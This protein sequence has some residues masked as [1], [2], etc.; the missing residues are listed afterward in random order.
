MP[1]HY[2]SPS[3]YKRKEYRRRYQEKSLWT[4][5]RVSGPRKE[6]PARD[7]E[8]RLRTTRGAY[9]HKMACVRCT[10][11]ETIKLKSPRETIKVKSPRETIKDAVVNIQQAR[12]GAES[13]RC[14][15][16]YSTSKRRRRERK[17]IK[18]STDYKQ[19]RRTISRVYGL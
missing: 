7:H 19:S 3:D 4:T 8:K 1:T 18:E 9:A 15:G 14:C 10:V 16:K 2:E 5:K 17:S 6:S 11:H 12:D 13:A